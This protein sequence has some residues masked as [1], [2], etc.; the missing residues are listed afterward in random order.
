MKLAGCYPDTEFVLQD[1]DGEEQEDSLCNHSEKLAVAFGILNLK[2]ESSIR[3]FKNLRICG[4][5]HNT[6]KFIS[7]FVGVQIIVRD[8]LRFHHFTHGTC[9]CGDFW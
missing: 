7:N 1:L 2:G 3:V 6:I 8:S 4:D 5:C 9:S